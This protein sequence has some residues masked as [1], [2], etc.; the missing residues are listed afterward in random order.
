MSTVVILRLVAD[1][2]KIS[3]LLEHLRGV[4]QVTRT[5]S[6]CE[7]VVIYQRDGEPGQFT[8][9]ECWESREHHERYVEW[10]Q[11]QG[12]LDDLNSLLSK[13]AIASYWNEVDV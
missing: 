3:N 2:G 9:I 8:A 10:R 5:Y 1:P 13:P 12:H 6:G 7:G 11:D 4:L